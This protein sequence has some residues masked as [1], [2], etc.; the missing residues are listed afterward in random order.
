MKTCTI[1]N[2]PAPRAVLFIDRDGTLVEEPPEDYQLDSLEKFAFIPGVIRNLGFIAE[3]LDFE[4]VM[5]TN[6]D[7]LGTE[8]FPMEDFLPSHNLLL[9]TL[10]GEGI[11]FDDIIIDTSFPH[12]NKPTRKPGTALLEKYMDGSRD[13]AASYVIGD[14]ITDVQ[15]ARNLGAKAIYFAPAERGNAEVRSNGLEESVALVTDD[16]ARIADFLR[17]G[18]R[19]VSARRT[20]NETDVEVNV[21]IDGR[22]IA[23]ISTG[24]GF[25]DHML[26]QLAR[27]SGI[28]MQVRVSGD[29]NVDSHHTIEDTAIVIGDVLR[30]AIGDK[31]GMERYGFVLPMDDCLCTLAL[32]FGGRSWIV[33]DVEFKREKI[34][35]MPTEMF[36]HFF[37]SLSDEARMNLHVSARGSNEH[38]KIEGIFKAFAH[39]LKAAV[40]RDVFRYELP[41]TKGSL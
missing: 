22:G 33:W 23:D 7:G 16:W 14:R 12:E 28:D 10:E 31:R 26:E 32:D 5:V 25:F 1:D 17:G 41:S 9:K 39:A 30:R 40:R 36:F 2:S 34:G 29:L 38:H 20:T 27:H 6:Q 13:I 37:K 15:L 3:N 35:D 8:S 24:V 19:K 4:L 21:D 11:H 18:T